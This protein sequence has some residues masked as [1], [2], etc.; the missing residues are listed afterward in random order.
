LE[1]LVYKHF[2]ARGVTE[3][4][5][6]GES[7]YAAY[8]IRPSGE[9]VSADLG[10][11][12]DIDYAVAAYRSSL[13]DPKRSDVR[14]KARALHERILQPLL[15]CIGN[16]THL[17]ISTDGQLSLIPFE[18]LVDER[19]RYAIER[20]SITYLST[21]RDLLRMRVQRDSNSGPVL[22]ADPDFGEPAVA[23][24]A[25]IQDHK[26][27]WTSQ[28]TVRRSVTSADDL[29]SVYFA[30]LSGTA[31]E[32]QAI[33][34]LFP[35]ARA[36]TGVRAKKSALEALQ[37][38]SL[39]HIATHGF[40]LR[41][42]QAEPAGVVGTRSIH[43]SSKIENPLLRSGLALTGANLNKRGFDNGILTALEASNLNLW[44]TKLVTLSA[45]DTGVGEVKNGEG[46]Y[47]LRRAFFL[48][49]TESL[50]MSLWPVSDYFT[51]ELMVQYYSG[52]KNGLGRG[53]ALRQAQLAILKRKGRQHPFYWASFI[54]AGEW[55]DLES[56]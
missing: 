1:F 39:L 12:K 56:R 31:R 11:A 14:E 10:P 55:T 21:G 27:S 38:P 7:R 43:A 50:V 34:S 28:L 47:G 18:S 45:C 13:S 17:L 15:G 37:A 46:V 48:A 3:K 54:E 24:V 5:Q 40:F 4:E 22:I 33:Q 6:L 20:Y 32:V 9:V 49:G 19:G 25:R 35:E 44:G 52:L 2:L 16:S 42:F 30:P 8:V 51:R 41:D 36:L 53:E 29:S 26:N 23:T